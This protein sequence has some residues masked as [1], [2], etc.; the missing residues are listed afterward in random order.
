[1][2]ILFQSAISGLRKIST[3]NFLMYG[4]G[5]KGL[6]ME[7]HSRRSTSAGSSSV[8]NYDAREMAIRLNESITKAAE[9]ARQEELHQKI[10]A[11]VTQRLTA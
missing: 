3:T 2:M 4:F 11:K 1:M 6:V 9:E 8:N 5:S 7:Q 10:G